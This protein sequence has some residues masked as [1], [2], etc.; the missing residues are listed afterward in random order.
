MNNQLIA[1]MDALKPENGVAG[2]SPLPSEKVSPYYLDYTANLNDSPDQPYELSY[3]PRACS[4]RYMVFAC[5]CGRHVR[6]STCM[7]L[8]CIPCQPWTTRRRAISAFNR[9]MVKPATV[10]YTIFTV[11]IMERYRFV[12]KA[13][14]QKVRKKAW[15]ILK[16]RF[17][18]LYGIE[19]SHPIGDDSRAFHPHLNIL[20]IQ[21]GGFSPYISVNDL[22]DAWA[23]VLSVT[24]ADVH[25]EYSNHP[26]KIMHW[27]KYALR[28]FPGFMHWSGAVRWYGKYPVVKRQDRIV[29][30]DCGSPYHVI[31]YILQCDYDE[32]NK[33][34]WLTGAAPPWKDDS[35]IIH[36]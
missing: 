19:A 31:G 22:R 21:R 2:K 14:W 34:G 9:L 20:W 15:Q 32:W 27:C 5:D 6:P 10:L 28:T 23:N 24:V 30:A 26:A 3:A 35:K 16:Q 12:D 11:P 13:V 18:A 4:P 29:C 36:T 8:D 25:T 7:N 1:I 33:T 17:G